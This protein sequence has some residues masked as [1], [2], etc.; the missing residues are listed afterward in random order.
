MNCSKNFREQEKFLLL[1]LIIVKRA[2]ARAN[3]VRGPYPKMGRL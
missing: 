2:V 3:E 1:N